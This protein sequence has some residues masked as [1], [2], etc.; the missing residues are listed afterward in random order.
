MTYVE[1]IR[2]VEEVGSERV[3][4]HVVLLQFK[5]GTTEEQLAEVGGAFM[6]LPARIPEIAR[7]E[8]GSAVNEGA[9]YTRCLMVTCHNEADLKSYENHPDHQAIPANFGHLLSGVVVLDYW[10]NA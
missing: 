5:D 3:L 10:T 2:S 4:R 6:A 1:K 8:W 7:L 9:S